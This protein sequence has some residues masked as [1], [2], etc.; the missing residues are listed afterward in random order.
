MTT[1]Q[2]SKYKRPL[3]FS[4]LLA[5]VL[6]MNITMAVIAQ[7]VSVRAT[8]QPSE[9][10]IGEQAL[11]DLQVIAPKNKRIKFPVYEKEIVPGIEVLTMLKPDTLIQNNVM[12]LHF[13]YVIT[14]FDSAL[15]NI[16]R[17][18]VFDGKETI[19]SNSFGLKVTSPVLK[20]ST[21]AYLQKMQSKQTDS[22]NFDELRFNDIKK[23]QKVPFICT[24]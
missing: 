12:T 5:V 13:K 22:I 18:P 4:K 1:N 9:I 8:V 16:P 23:I 10:Q 19:Y 6:F 21:V 3:S 20:D 14:S 7:G 2:N 15:Y 17:I 24:D 11:I